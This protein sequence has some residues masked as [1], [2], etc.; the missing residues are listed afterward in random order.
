MGVLNEKS[1]QLR[2][3]TGYRGESFYSGTL[4]L[5]LDE[6][7]STIINHTRSSGKHEIRQPW[8][9][10]SMINETH[11]WDS[12]FG[13]KVKYINPHLGLPYTYIRILSS[14]PLNLIK[15]TVFSPLDKKWAGLHYVNPKP[16]HRSFMQLC[17]SGIVDFVAYYVHLSYIS[18][19]KSWRWIGSS[20]PTLSW[21]QPPP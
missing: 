10:W 11:L 19:F 15:L 4:D 18:R 8:H 1:M 9:K 2:S 14:H 5:Y 6:K 3:N 7:L 17:R 12:V 13:I 20:G 16:T 21:T